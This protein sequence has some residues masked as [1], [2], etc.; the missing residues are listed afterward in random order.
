MKVVEEKLEEKTKI[1]PSLWVHKKTGCVGLFSCASEYVVLVKGNQ[2]NEVGEQMSSLVSLDE[3][4]D[5]YNSIITLSNN[6]H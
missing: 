3:N 1:F 2:H 6:S 4:W 5:F